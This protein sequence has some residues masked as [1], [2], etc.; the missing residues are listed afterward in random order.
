[1]HLTSTGAVASGWPASGLNL[2]PEPGAQAVGAIVP[3]DSGGAVFIWGDGRNANP[4]TWAL[5]LNADGTVAAGWPANGIQIT[6]AQGFRGAVPDHAGGFYAWSSTDPA[7]DGF[8]YQLYLRRFTFA[9][10]TAPGWPP[11]GILVCNAPGKRGATSISE[12]GAGG[13]LLT[14]Y[15]YR[16]NYNVSGNYVFALRVLPNGALAPGW[17][18]DGTLVS[19]PTTSALL[20]NPIIVPD[21]HGGGYIAWYGGDPSW[22]QHLAASGQV[23]AGWPTYGLRVAPS[24]GQFDADIAPDGH[25]GAI[26]AWDDSRHGIFVQSYAT[27]GPV[28]VELSLVNA[29]VKDGHVDLDWYSAGT[30]LS[31]ATVSRRTEN[32]AWSVLGDVAAD[33]TGHLRYEDRDVSPGQGYAY[34]LGYV[35]GGIMRFTAET[36]IYV[37]QQFELALAG[38][39][40][41]P[42]AGRMN[43]AFSLRDASPASLAMLDVAG[44][45]VMRR[46]VG[47]LGPGRHVVTM[48]P[49]ARLASG[50]YWLRLTQGGRSLLARA[51]VIR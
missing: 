14:W 27:D 43:V 10:T 25:G 18:T 9:G 50:L 33:G 31:N 39:R 13:V 4:D 6:S 17:T 20:Y 26:V 45:A 51:V 38:A 15:D 23:A 42:S 41:N 1:L 19:D 37:T 24:S 48:E 11:A 46:E 3:D 32:S 49:E 12:D 21:D 47:S 29:E 16:P 7:L 5:R 34:R 44:R 8:D 30:A 35:D 22:V 36:W 2:T 40:P 28:P